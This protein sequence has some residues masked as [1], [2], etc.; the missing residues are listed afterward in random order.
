MNA[1][2]ILVILLILTTSGHHH[3]KRL[4][5]ALCINMYKSCS[6]VCEKKPTHVS[7]HK[8]S[9]CG[10]TWPKHIHEGEPRVFQPPV[11]D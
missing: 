4:C 5:G 2:L 6:G 7:P 10:Y 11:Q 3:P 9:H 1:S 8:C